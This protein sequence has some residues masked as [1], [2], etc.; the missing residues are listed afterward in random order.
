MAEPAAIKS[1]TRIHCLSSDSEMN[2]YECIMRH[3]VANRLKKTGTSCF[4]CPAARERTGKLNTFPLIL[5]LKSF[6]PRWI[7]LPDLKKKMKVEQVILDQW[8]ESLA[9]TGVI[10]LDTLITHGKET[11]I[12]RLRSKA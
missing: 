1:K 6:A 12:V 2:L 3:L 11:K 8:L 9:L 4:S 10:E 5:Q 7:A